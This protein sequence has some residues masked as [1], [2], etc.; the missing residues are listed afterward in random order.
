M[1]F[2]KFVFSAAGI[3][4]IVVLTPLYWLVDITG[5]R[6]PVPVEYPHFYYG[7]ISVA[8]AWQIAFLIIGSS[9][10]RFRPLMIAGILE[11]IGHVVGVAVLYGQRRIPWADAQGG[12]PDLALGI[13]FVLAFAKTRHERSQLEQDER[14]E[15]VRAVRDDRRP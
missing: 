9:P 12:V 13:L 11:K 2:A 1:K 5:R 15:V 4:G 3:W 6:Y 8:M 10:A 7:F 14:Q